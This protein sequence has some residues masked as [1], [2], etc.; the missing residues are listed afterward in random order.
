MVVLREIEYILQNAQV[1]SVC[2][3]II[4][5]ILCLFVFVFP[6]DVTCRNLQGALIGPDMDKLPKYDFKSLNHAG[7]LK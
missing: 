5:F 4:N 7:L 6:L 2:F 1:H 3:F